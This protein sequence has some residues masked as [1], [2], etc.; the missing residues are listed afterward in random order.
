[1]EEDLA[2]ISALAAKL[3]VETR[4]QQDAVLISKSGSA[5]LLMRNLVSLRIAAESQK[6]CYALVFGY[7]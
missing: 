3:G 1:M 5:G 4:A 7:V 2:T 6:R